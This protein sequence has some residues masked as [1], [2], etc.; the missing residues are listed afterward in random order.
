MLLR[1]GLLFFLLLLI[2]VSNS[3]ANPIPLKKISA[4]YRPMYGVSYSFEQAG[5]YGLNPR[6]D[7]IKLLDEI[8][9]NWVRLPF[10]WDQMTDAD[11]NLKL[12]DLK[13][14][15]EAAG[16]RNA[17]VLIALGAK[18]PFYPETHFPAYIKER[19]KF[20]ERLTPDHPIADELI[21][22]DK[23][24]VEAL[25]GYSN[26]SH[27]Q[28]ENEPLLGDPRGVSVS[29][30]LVK[31]EVE[32]VRSSDPAKRPIIVNHPAGWYFDN[33]WLELINILKPGDVYS[34][35]AYFKTKG[36]HL[37][38]T[39]VGGLEVT[40]PWPDSITWPVQNW[41]F[42][43]P[44]YQKFKR[45]A[46]KRGAKFWIMEMQA[47]PY[48]RTLGDAMKPNF[49]FSPADIEEGNQF[50]KSFGVESVGLWG[51]HFWQFK[52]KIGDRS[53]LEATQKI[54]RD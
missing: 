45:E 28:V 27:W 32:A 43:S 8:K 26:I 33:N 44:P 18:T 47:E 50:L 15:I 38:A 11:G 48:I 1:A 41:P 12:D 42:L 40:V 20:G 10:F 54:T 5:W 22:V 16:K 6:E 34:T 17:Q 37:I 39:R 30:D 46:E 24:L 21:T 29:V 2:V 25:S 35:N 14:A 49:A 31:R 19:I 7:Y 4:D 3:F 13:F 36:S 23:K 51:A 53:W 9:P 52:E